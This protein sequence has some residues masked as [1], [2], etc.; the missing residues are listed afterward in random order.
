MIPQEAEMT[1]LNSLSE[2]SSRRTLLV[3]FFMSS[4]LPLLIM[5]MMI[6]EY[7]IPSL[8][9]ERIDRLIDLFTFGF[10]AMLLSSVISFFL[11]SR[12]IGSLL[13]LSKEIKEKS[14]S[15]LE[16]KRESVNENEIEALRNAFNS[17]S[18]ELIEKVGKLKQYADDVIVCNRKLSSLAL[19]DQL[20]SLYNRRQFETTLVEERNRA[21]R[22]Q[23]GLSLIMIDINQF[24]FYNDTY[25]HQTGDKILQE[26]GELFRG[27]IRKTDI[28]FRYGGDEFAILL[29]ETSQER[30]EA[31]SDKLIAAVSNHPF[32]GINKTPIGEVTICCGV[33]SYCHDQDIESFVKEADIALY[34]NRGVRNQIPS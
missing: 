30:A 16:T 29:P 23:H 3:F 6:Y 33:S 31:L 28:P 7:V 8:I 4:I 10:A 26:L 18:D 22:F 13:A 14:S 12:R 11:M 2:E 25:G 34:K 32:V 19:I 17:L 1:F 27:S 9:P 5:T 20:T 15:L 21:E 24:K